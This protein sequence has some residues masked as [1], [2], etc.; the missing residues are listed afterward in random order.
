M[1][2]HLRF[3]L[4]KV[5]PTEEE[6]EEIFNDNC[7]SDLKAGICNVG[8]PNNRYLSLPPNIFPFEV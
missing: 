7:L 5:F 6:V 3:V 2:Y 1:L 4:G 8:D